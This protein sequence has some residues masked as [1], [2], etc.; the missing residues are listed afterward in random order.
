MTSF[1]RRT[2]AG[3]AS[4]FGLRMFGLFLM[5]PVFAVY[6]TDLQGAT[7][8][9]IGLAIGV[10]GLTQ[11]CL[12][13]PM[14]F[15]SD[16]LGRRPIILG[17]LLL[18]AVGSV[19][20]ALSDHIVGV[21]IGRA[22][23]GG[24][25]I[26][27]AVMALAAD[28]TAPKQR[29][30]MMAII[31][32]SVGGAFL[33]AMILGP[34]L[35]GIGGLALIFWLSAVLAVVAIVVLYAVVPVPSQQRVHADAEPV[36][37]QFG[38]VLRNPDLLRLDGGIFILHFILT[39]AFVVLPLMLRDTLSLPV[40][41]HWQVYVPVLLLSVVAL[42]PAV[43]I[44]ERRHWHRQVIVAAVVCL[45][46][47][48]LALAAGGGA[49]PVLLVGLWLWF[50]AFNVLEAT[51][52]SLISRYAPT[53]S[54]GTALGVYATSQFAGAFLGGLFGGI[55]HGLGGEAWVFLLCALGTMAWLV[56]MRGMG[57]VPDLRR[58]AVSEA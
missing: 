27:A 10:Y 44:S 3:L 24:G 11:A 51:L 34:V 9:L 17:G 25:A 56:I 19:V 41:A 48:Q 13:I 42:V 53:E 33:L 30:M 8:A 50:A 16:R 32:M 49:A 14:G 21:I 58:D 31:G 57:Q 2:A 7:P 6:G 38:G 23:Q 5:L 36:R 35:V 52:P 22:L 1:E 46:V 28:L 55:V 15:A 18:F 20:A 37:S 40:G 47:A 29:T 45:T 39:A 43:M 4:I 26:A 12:Q 54:K